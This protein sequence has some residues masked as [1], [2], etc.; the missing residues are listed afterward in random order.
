M[1]RAK[2]NAKAIEFLT[3]LSDNSDLDYATDDSDV[4]RTWQPQ[5]AQTI[6]ASDFSE[7]DEEGILAETENLPVVST[8]G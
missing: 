4:D 5:K 6:G 8:S 2:L 7:L 1:R 3:T